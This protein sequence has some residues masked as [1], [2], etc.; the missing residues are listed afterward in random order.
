MPPRCRRLR[1]QECHM[2]SF[3]LFA[4]FDMF[5]ILFCRLFSIFLKIYLFIYISIDFLSGNVNNEP[6]NPQEGQNQ[7]PQDDQNQNPPQEEQKILQP[8]PIARPPPSTQENIINEIERGKTELEGPIGQL[9]QC[10][11]TNPMRAQLALSLE[12]IKTHIANV[13]GQLDVWRVKREEQKRYYANKL[14]Y[15]DVK[16]R[17]T[18]R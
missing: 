10:G 18:K 13:S 11:Q 5:F 14:S 8:E 3:F 16:K 15:Q 7:N 17:Y 6:A 1:S 4:L 12:S 9:K 2:F